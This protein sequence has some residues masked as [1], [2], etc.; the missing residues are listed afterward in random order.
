MFVT[1]PL[2]V[3]VNVAVPPVATEAVA[4]DTLTEVTT[5]AEIVTVDDA[6][7]VLSALLVAVTVSVP[8]V[9]GAV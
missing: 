1:V 6:D 5:G 4:G 9:D 8:A 7:L 3:A 2:T